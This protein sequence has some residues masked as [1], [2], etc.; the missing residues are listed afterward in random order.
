MLYELHVLTIDRISYRTIKQIDLTVCWPKIVLLFSRT[1]SIIPFDETTRL[2]NRL[3]VDPI[4]GFVVQ[5][6]NTVE[7]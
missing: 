2:A 7:N 4:D 1:T 5:W 3:L 6:R